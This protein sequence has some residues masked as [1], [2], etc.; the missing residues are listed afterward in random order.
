MGYAPW[1]R[2]KNVL[3]TAGPKNGEFVSTRLTAMHHSAEGHLGLGEIV[4]AGL[5]VLALVGFA[6]TIV[7]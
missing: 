7:R 5:I 1:G 4:F 3:F 6:L 2:M